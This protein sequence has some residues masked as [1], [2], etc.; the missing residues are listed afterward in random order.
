MPAR[1]RRCARDNANQ[2]QSREHNPLTEHLQSGALPLH[3]GSAGCPEH[4]DRE[5]RRDNRTDTAQAG[6]NTETGNSAVTTGR[7]PASTGV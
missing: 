5:Q 7:T 3:T 2:G 1:G 4:G 6:L